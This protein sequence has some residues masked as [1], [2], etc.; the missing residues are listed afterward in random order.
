MLSQSRVDERIFTFKMCI[1]IFFLS[2]DYG[3]RIFNSESGK[4]F[5]LVLTSTDAE[6]MIFSLQ[7]LGLFAYSAMVLARSFRVF[8]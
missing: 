1:N 4:T 6:W 8:V 3:Q 2:G 5:L 7:A